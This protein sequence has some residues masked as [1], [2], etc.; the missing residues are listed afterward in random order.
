MSE[1]HAPVFGVAGCG[2]MGLPMARRLAAAGFEVWGFDVR[3]ADEF[4]D[5]AERMVADAV[6]FARRVDVVISVVRDR[7]Q[8][9][10]LCFDE[11]G[12][13]KADG[14]P[15]TLIV[16]ST[17]SPGVLLEIAERMPDG[18]TLI[19]APM[20]G[21][22]ARADDGALTFMV[23]G[24]ASAVAAMMPAF[25]A[26]GRDI[27]HLGGSGAGM[28][29]KVVNNFLAVS[30]FVAVRK[31]MASAERLGLDPKTLLEV[32]RSSSGSTW[33]GDNM[34]RISWAAEGYAPEN[35]IGILEKDLLSYLEA[36][37][38]DGGEPGDFE[39]ALLSEVRRMTP[40]QT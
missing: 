10:D 31:A 3:P 24:E 21:A 23:G 29:C 5:F 22:P 27:H 12:I 39:T 13:F 20:S 11:Q 35:T 34:A 16:S 40:L 1:N 15:T 17:L 38:G 4:S 8:T 26:M 30:G 14:R 2:A 18:T 7:R 36:L 9:M 28:T 33:Y 6:A 19:D 37:G 32:A 25:R